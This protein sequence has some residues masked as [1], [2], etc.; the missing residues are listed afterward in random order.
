M[1][2][3]ETLSTDSDAVFDKELT[4][5]GNEIEPM[6]TYGTN[7]GMGTGISKSIPR[8]ED[9]EGGVATYKYPFSIISFIYRKKKVSKRAEN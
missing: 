2:Y 4:F 8:A 6:I 3:W 7:P 9:V 5:N 1:K